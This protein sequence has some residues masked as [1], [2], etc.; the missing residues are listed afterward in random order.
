LASILSADEVFGTH[1]GQKYVRQS[2][3][4][5]ES[6]YRLRLEKALAKKAASLGYKLVPETLPTYETTARVGLP[7]RSDLMSR[8][9]RDA[10]P[11]RGGEVADGS[12]SQS[13]KIVTGSAPSKD[14]FLGSRSFGD[15]EAYI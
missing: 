12:P 14:L 6:A 15:A 13:Y 9:P 3:E 8:P 10:A 7:R 11:A 1:N 2:E 4:A 5:Y